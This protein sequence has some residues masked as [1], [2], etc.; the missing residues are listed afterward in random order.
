MTV[1]ISEI[2]VREH[3]DEWNGVGDPPATGPTFDTHFDL[4]AVPQMPT[5]AEVALGAS[6][7][8]LS[9]GG[10]DD[11]LRYPHTAMGADHLG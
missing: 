4:E 7:R 6:A 5:E 8:V 3:W 1:H 11:S 9:W 10:D 2:Y